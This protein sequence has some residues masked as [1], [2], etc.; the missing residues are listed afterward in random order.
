MSNWFV[1]HCRAWYKLWSSWL[2]MVWGAIVTAVWI[3]PDTL[4]SLTDLLPDKYREAVSPLVFTFIAGL[5]IIVR[6]L[7]Q[8]LPK[9]DNNA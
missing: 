8:N 3:E 6:L 2:A 1:D 9:G 7:K 4:K 5:P